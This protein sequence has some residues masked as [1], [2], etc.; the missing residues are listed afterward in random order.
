MHVITLCKKCEKVIS[1][2]KPSGC[3]CK[4]NKRKLEY[5]ICEKCKEKPDV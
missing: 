2:S 5:S 4:M 1:E 3:K